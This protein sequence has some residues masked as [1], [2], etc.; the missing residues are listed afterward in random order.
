MPAPGRS[1]G[2]ATGSA[3]HGTSAG[4]P[5]AT[6]SGNSP[7]DRAPYAGLWNLLARTY[8]AVESGAEPP[9]SMR[10]IAEVNDLV[11]A[12]TAEEFRF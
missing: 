5:T 11:A 8:E 3:R 9:V 4:P 10:Q 2:C 12:L 7:P 6:S 1:R